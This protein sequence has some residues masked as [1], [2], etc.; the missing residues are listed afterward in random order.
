MFKPRPT[1]DNVDFQT[2]IRF[3]KQNWMGPVWKNPTDSIIPLLDAN[4]E[5]IPAP[6]KKEGTLQDA[7][8]SLDYSSPLVWGPYRNRRV[9]RGSN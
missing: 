8:T 1:E 3:A 9:K 4:L 2:L 6:K 7:N 5:H